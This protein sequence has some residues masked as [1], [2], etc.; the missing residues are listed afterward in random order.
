VLN[1]STLSGNSAGQGGGIYNDGY[2]SSNAAVTINASTLSGNSA[3]QGGGIYNEGQ[4]TSNA[5]SAQVLIGDTILNGGSGGTLANVSGAVVSA[6]YNLSSDSAGGF[7]TKATDILNAAP[8]LGPLQNNGGPTW[9]CALLARSPAINQGKA[10]AVPGLGLA[11][12]QRGLPRPVDLAG[13]DKAPGGD[14]SDIGAFEAQ[15]FSG[16][17]PLLTAAM[18]YGNGSFQFGFTDNSAGATFTILTTTNL[19]LPINDWRVL[20]GAIAIAPGQFQF[21]DAQATNCLQQFYGVISP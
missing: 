18:N 1:T 5:A 19:A 14:G 9:T 15:V 16:N 11:A 6:G 17:P 4:Q 21:T 10:N 13:I 12:D 7:L 8:L 2:A 20:G 3:S